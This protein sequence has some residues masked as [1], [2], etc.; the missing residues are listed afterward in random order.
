MPRF[1]SG[2]VGRALLLGLAVSLGVS[3][4][5]RVGVLAGW[6]TRAVDTFLALRDRG[7][8]PDLVIVPIDEA[9]FR[10]LGERQPL[11]RRYLAD[12][13]GLLVSSGA[14][15]VAFDVQF[16]APT[17]AQEDAALLAVAWRAGSTGG[18]TRLV[19]ATVAEPRPGVAP[20]RYEMGAL[21]SRPRSA[22]SSASPTLR[23]ARTASFAGSTRCCPPSAAGCPRSPSRCSPRTPASL[24]AS[25]RRRATGGSA[26]R[27]ARAV[28]RPA[29][30][31][32]LRRCAPAP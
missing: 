3:A 14:R 19:W 26:A 30:S 12:L 5:S 13:T 25:R 4:L 23:W 32:A 2:R 8:A 10:E 11:S 31:R 20:P 21:L 17:S 22:G 28:A 16:R 27:A 18:A 29:Q 24:P 15:V 7:S 9:A 1:L 6:E